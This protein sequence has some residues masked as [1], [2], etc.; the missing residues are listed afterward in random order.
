[1]DS[2]NNFTIFQ[3]VDFEEELESII[4]YLRKKTKRTWYCTKIL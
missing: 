3:T 2:T 4:Y 1:M